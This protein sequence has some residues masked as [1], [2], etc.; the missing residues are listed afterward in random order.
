MI[1]KPLKNVTHSC[2]DRVVLNSHK[3]ITVISY[4]D[5]HNFECTS[6]RNFR[7]RISPKHTV[8]RYRTQVNNFHCDTSHL[9]FTERKLQSVERKWEGR[10]AIWGAI[11]GAIE[12]PKSAYIKFLGDFSR[13]LTNFSKYFLERYSVSVTENITSTNCCICLD[14]AGFR[15]CEGFDIYYVNQ[16]EANYW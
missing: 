3:F 16:T 1:S 5:P 11:W 14:T 15:G 7:K 8:A 6:V 10:G 9:P 4:Q 12:G 13:G 2:W